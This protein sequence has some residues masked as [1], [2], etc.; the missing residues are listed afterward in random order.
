MG[1]MAVSSGSALSVGSGMKRNDTA[2]PLKVA[3]NTERA[4]FR[5]PVGPVYDGWFA[6][7]ASNRNVVLVLLREMYDSGT[8]RRLFS[9]EQLAALLGSPNRQAVDGHMQG[10]READGDLGGYLSRTRNVDAAVVELVWTTWSAKPYVR[11]V[12]S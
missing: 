7:T 8:G 6:N 10:F 12:P 4:Q 11:L 9:E 5:V 1:A 2:E 3:W